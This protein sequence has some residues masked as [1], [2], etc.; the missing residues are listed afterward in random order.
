MKE[1]IHTRSHI[2]W[3]HLYEISNIDKSIQTENR[4]VAASELR[5]GDKRE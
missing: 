4:L 1:V 2:T 3:F 5:V